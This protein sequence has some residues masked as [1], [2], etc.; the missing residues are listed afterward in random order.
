M[1]KVL[2]SEISYEKLVRL[3]KR[4]TYT[5][6]IFHIIFKQAKKLDY[7]YIQIKT[8]ITNQFK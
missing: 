8:N 5:D 7:K 6:C 1:F 4:L 3:E 2:C